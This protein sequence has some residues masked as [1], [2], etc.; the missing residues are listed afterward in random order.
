MEEA[1]VQGRDGLRGER[2]GDGIGGQEREGDRVGGIVGG[3]E[4]EGEGVGD[5]GGEEGCGTAIRRLE[6]Q[7]SRSGCSEKAAGGME[8]G[9]EVLFLGGGR[10]GVKKLLLN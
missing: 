8:V 3:Q 7:V 6:I 5:V 1:A 4:R 9:V 2:E 10:V